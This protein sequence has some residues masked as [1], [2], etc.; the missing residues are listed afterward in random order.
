MGAQTC[1]LPRFRSRNLDI[2]FMTLKFEGN[3]DVSPYQKNQISRLWHSKQRAW[4]EKKLSLK[5][6]SEAQ[7][8]KI[9]IIVKH[10]PIKFHQFLTNG[11]RVASFR[12][13]LRW[14]WPWTVM[15]LKLEF[16]LRYSEA[17]SPHR[18]RSCWFK[19]LE[20]YIALEIKRYHF[21]RSWD[22][23]LP[24]YIN[25]WPVVFETVCGQTHTQTDV[26]KY[27]SPT[28]LQHS[29]RAGAVQCRHTCSFQYI[30]D[31]HG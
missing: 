14:P 13:L 22:I 26:A 1:V 19:P 11:V 24:S 2:N 17:V 30:M 12:F 8:S 5:I 15:T 16:W 21:Q 23:F 29:W 31:F 18:K 10:I 3:R 27:N 6:K 25:F 4:I 7:M 9:I 20:S 28:G